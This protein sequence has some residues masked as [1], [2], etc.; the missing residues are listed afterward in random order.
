[1]L[2]QIKK[3]K[4]GITSIRKD[5]DPTFDQNLIEIIN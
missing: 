4:D 5:T 3:V 1:M 2:L